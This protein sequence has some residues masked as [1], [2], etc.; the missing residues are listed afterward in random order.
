MAGVEAVSRLI[1]PQTPTH[2][3]VLAGAGAI[4][5]AGNWVAAVIRSRSGR[6]LDSAALVADGNHARAD[7]YVSLAVIASAAVVALG[8]P[9][10]DPLIGLG[11]TAVI[12]RI[13][14]DSWLTVRADHVDH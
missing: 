5:F 1:H 4:G 13:T 8:A 2:L 11:I 14:W 7:A 10:A 9:I 3:G 6:V 12:L